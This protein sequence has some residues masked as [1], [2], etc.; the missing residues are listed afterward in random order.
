[1]QARDEG[2]W[3][4]KICVTKKQAPVPGVPK[5]GQL[6]AAATTVPP[7]EAVL[8]ELRVRKAGARNKHGVGQAIGQSVKIV[9]AVILCAGLLADS[10]G[11]CNEAGVLG[12]MVAV[13]ATIWV[14][15]VARS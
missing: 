7:P 6:I 15:K 8:R 12:A 2:A 14:F 10:S 1:M 4:F 5:V 9:S 11:L 3:E 13:D